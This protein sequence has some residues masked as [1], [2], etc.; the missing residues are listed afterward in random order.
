[1]KRKCA[2]FRTQLGFGEAFA[3][4]EAFNNGMPRT[5]QAGYETLVDLGDR[6]DAYVAAGDGDVIRRSQPHPAAC[7][8]INFVIVTVG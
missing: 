5:L 7:K 6:W 8:K 4:W 2:V 1:V 3:F